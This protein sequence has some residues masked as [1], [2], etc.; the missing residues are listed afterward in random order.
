[1]VQF[2]RWRYEHVILNGTKQSEESLLAG[3]GPERFFVAVLLLRNKIP[4]PCRRGGPSFRASNAK[5]GIQ[6]HK[7]GFLPPRE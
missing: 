4:H 5:P 1:M 3:L 2:D 6:E 7:T